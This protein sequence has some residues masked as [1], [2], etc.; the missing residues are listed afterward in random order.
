MKRLVA[1]GLVFNFFYPK[2]VIMNHSINEV[3][4][5]MNKY[6]YVLP[7]FFLFLMN[8]PVIAQKGNDTKIITAVRLDM[9]TAKV[10]LDGIQIHSF[11]IDKKGV[12]RPTKGYEIVYRS[13]FKQVI[14]KPKGRQ[15]PING[16][17]E[18]EVPGGTMYCLCNGGAADNCE[19][20]VNIADKELLYFCA[21]SC[22]C[23]SFTIYDVSYPVLEY[24]TPGGRWFGF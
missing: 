21:G 24:E 3:I 13:E 12:L 22:G 14:I 10:Y 20:Q 17:E 8:T 11:N 5:K 23:G 4:Q 9:A 19:F 6:I 2:F 1:V 16:Y 15:I 18:I 7:I